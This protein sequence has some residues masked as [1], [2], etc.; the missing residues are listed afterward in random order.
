MAKSLHHEF[1]CNFGLFSVFSRC[2]FDV[3]DVDCPDAREEDI[4]IQK[5]SKASVEVWFFCSRRKHSG[6]V[7]EENAQLHAQAFII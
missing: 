2:T 7:I 6:A 3:C 1:D 5:T 4:K